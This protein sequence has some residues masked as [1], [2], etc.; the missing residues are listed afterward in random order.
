MRHTVW[1]M[2]EISG[3]STDA[4]SAGGAQLSFDEL[5]TPLEHTT[6][7]VLDLETTGGSNER[8][9][10][11]EIAAVKI[12]G[13]EVI[14]EF[15]TLVNPGRPIPQSVVSI[16]GITDA[17]VAEA[18]ELASIL[19]SLIEFCG[20]AV[21]VAHN[22]AFDTGFLRTNYEAHGFDWPKPRVLCTVRLARRLVGRDETP[23]H[24]LATLARVLKARTEPRH[25][26]LRDA[27]ATVDVL[28]A[29]L[30]RAAGFG[31]RSL[32]ELFEFLP[33]VTEHQRRKRSLADGLP[34]SAGVYLF[35][36]PRDEVLYVG[37]ATDL[38]RRVRQ[39]FTGGER[40]GRIK[41]MVSIAERVDH[42]TCAH[43][44]EAE[45]RELRLLGAHQP[46]YNRRSKFPGSVWWV[47]LTDEP[48]PRLT[49]TR[50]ARGAALGPFR[51]RRDAADA[52]EGIHTATKVRQC[53]DRIP[54]TGQRATPCVVHE[55]GRCDAP[56]AGLA[57]TATYEPQV[58]PV[59]QL[60]HGEDDTVLRTLL[61]RIDQ[62]ALE[63]RFEDAAEQRDRLVGLVRAV[64]RGQR[65]SSLAQVPELVAARPDGAGG[66]QL[67]V[68]RH[69]RLAAAGNAAR[70]TPPMPVVDA[71]QASAET[72]VPEQDPLCGAS[73]DEA[74]VVHR[75]LAAGDTRMVRC[76][77]PWAEPAGSAGR[78]RSWVQAAARARDPYPG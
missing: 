27:R 75:W 70:G 33:G 57:D 20:G 54:A 7:V 74:H 23:N 31:V 22:A 68:V 48:F 67:A 45:V 61:E 50:K 36:G 69:A 25:R 44:L 30:E 24:K 59:R 42:V 29:L 1:P 15:D 16:T 43:A 35:R 73:V 3:R 19:P 71:L 38:H 10:I 41:E 65:L 8:D 64:D 76:T 2:S 58:I 49:I 37:T 32:E 77:V 12:R 51:S 62:V 17:M 60:L 46:R 13:G 53:T 52:V 34:N 4:A 28:H 21:L 55:L 63:Q 18:P 39:Y 56:C 9:S 6:F 47:S 14:G 78:W 26:A 5:G 40:R 11:T 66:W 72:V